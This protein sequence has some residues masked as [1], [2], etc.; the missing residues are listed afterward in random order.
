M[1]VIAMIAIF[2]TAVGTS[3][4][5]T[6]ERARIEKASR[7]TFCRKTVWIVRLE[8]PAPL[9]PTMPASTLPSSPKSS[10]LKSTQPK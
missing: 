10:N 8:N 1:V 5:K 3:V 7:K 6:R 4:G 2:M 9:A